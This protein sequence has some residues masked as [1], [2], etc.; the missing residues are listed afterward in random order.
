M[1]I[2]LLFKRITLK[3]HKHQLACIKVIETLPSEKNSIQ[4]YSRSRHRNSFYLCNFEAD[5]KERV[6]SVI[7]KSKHALT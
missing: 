6:A 3:F 1:H 4:C 2:N 7:R 5:I